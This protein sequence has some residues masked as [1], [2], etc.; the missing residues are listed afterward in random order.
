MTDEHVFEKPC[1][2]CGHDCA[3]TV[4]ARV[5]GYGAMSTVAVRE[6]QQCGELWGE[7]R[8]FYGV[9]GE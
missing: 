8:D 3:E 7:E 1:P 9:L 2:H 4:D 6:C 5:R